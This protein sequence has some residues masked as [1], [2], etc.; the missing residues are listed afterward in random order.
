MKGLPNGIKN[1]L[2]QQEK[3]VRKNIAYI[4]TVLWEFY[5][6]MNWLLFLKLFVYWKITDQKI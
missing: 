1:T 4:M 3:A 5:D 2:K 6:R